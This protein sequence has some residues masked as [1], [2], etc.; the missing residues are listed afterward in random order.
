MV[1]V[2]KLRILYFQNDIPVP[3]KLKSGYEL[4]IYPVKVKDW[5]YFENSI[6]ILTIKKNEINDINII[7]MSYLQFIHEV[8]IPS[9]ELYQHMFFNI[10][11]KSLHEQI[12]YLD[13]SKGKSVVVVGGD[14]GEIKA[15]IN[16]KEFDEIS[17]IIL[18]QNIV[19]YDDRDISPEVRGLMEEY[20]KLK[21]QDLG[22]PTLERKKVYV[23]GKTGISMS[24]LNEMTYRTFSQVY[25]SE[26]ESEL[27]VAQKMIQASPKYDTGKENVVH[28][29]FEKKKDPY[30]EMF[31]D[32]E[33]FKQRVGNGA[34]A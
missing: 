34:K 25:S 33:S 15:L 6:P 14:N 21:N 17:K 26:L 12:F 16:H 2:E 4:N 20:Q 1:D 3:Y 19:D 8:L 22:S 28:P 23:I 10:M 32:N 24:E 30:E 31:V 9:E 18:F 7:Q 5:G 27:Y 29:L 11:S 13:K